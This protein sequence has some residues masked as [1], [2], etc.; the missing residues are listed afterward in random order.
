MSTLLTFIKIQINKYHILNCVQLKVLEKICPGEI[1][2]CRQSS[3]SCFSWTSQFCLLWLSPCTLW[4]TCTELLAPPQRLLHALSGPLPVL[5]LLLEP[6]P[7]PPCHLIP[8]HSPGL[9]ICSA[10]SLLT[11]PPV[12]E[13]SWL[14]L[15]LTFP[16]SGAYHMVLPIYCSVFLSG[17]EVSWGQEAYLY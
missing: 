12:R 5:L 16:L 17:L 2:V 10:K 13:P 15:H 4:S 8:L 11:L 14:P 9:S 6:L 7:P 1:N 3:S